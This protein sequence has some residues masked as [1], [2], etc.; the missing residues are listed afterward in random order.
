MVEDKHNDKK[1]RLGKGARV[2]VT[3]WARVKNKGKYYE[4]GLGLKIRIIS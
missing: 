2:R 3:S 1:L 4:L